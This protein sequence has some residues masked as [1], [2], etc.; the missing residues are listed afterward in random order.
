MLLLGVAT[1]RW[2]VSTSVVVLLAIVTLFGG[3]G[4]VVMKRTV[5][6]RGV[7]FPRV[8]MGLLLV[9]LRGRWCQRRRWRLLLLL[10]QWM[11]LRRRWR[12]VANFAHHGRRRWLRVV[13]FGCLVAHHVNWRWSG[14]A[15]LLGWRLLG[16]P[17]VELA[18]LVHLVVVVG[19]VWVFVRIALA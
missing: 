15:G 6:C 16:V 8:G 19:G 5:S 17:R 1:V 3:G 18:P 2:Y 7:E 10:R 9:L 11:V 14:M 4:D 13:G 12:H